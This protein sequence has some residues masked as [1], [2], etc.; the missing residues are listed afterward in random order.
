MVVQ[1]P[2]QG[3]AAPADTS[4]LS[5]DSLVALA[6]WD[7][8]TAATRL[9]VTL[10]G[11]AEVYGVLLD[12]APGVAVDNIPMRGCSGQ[13]FTQIDS[14]LLA[15]SYALLDVGLIIL[16]F[17]GNSVPFIKG[18]KALET[19]CQSIGRQIDR[20][21]RCCPHASILFVG[22]ADMA[23]QIDGTI[24][25]YPYME[26]I[27]DGLRATVNAHGAAYWSQ[28]DAMGGRNTIKSWVRQGLAGSDYIHFSQQGAD[29]MGDLLADA[30][31]TMY[32][33][34]RLRRTSRSDSL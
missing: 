12:D 15:A 10:Q 21:H 18:E 6:L 28:Y 24:Q 20:L 26:R 17:G 8:D 9:R 33:Y 31:L 25:S 13:Q 2:K 11:S 22:P 32:R 3:R 34:Y 1:S 5:G 30:L 19:Y 29:L 16:Q 23:A 7:A 27:I 4:I 14:A